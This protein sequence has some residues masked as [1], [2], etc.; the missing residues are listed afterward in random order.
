MAATVVVQPQ[1]IIKSIKGV[2][3]QAPILES[4]KALFMP[5]PVEAKK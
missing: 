1:I 3:L 2:M 4:T 5:M